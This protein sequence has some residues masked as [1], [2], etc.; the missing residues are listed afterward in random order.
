MFTIIMEDAGP[1]NSLALDVAPNDVLDGGVQSVFQGGTERHT[2]FRIHID[3][4]KELTACLPASPCLGKMLKN[5]LGL[6]LLDRLRHCVKDV[7][8]HAARSS[9]LDHRPRRG[10]LPSM[11][12]RKVGT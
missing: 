5:R 7:I 1:P 8:V 10:T 4:R 11:K 9:G 2:L 12:S 3:K 6:F